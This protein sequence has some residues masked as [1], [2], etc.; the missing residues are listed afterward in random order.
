MAAPRV[1]LAF[2]PESG[3]PDRAAL[4]AAIKPLGFDFVVDPAWVPF[5]AP[6]YLPC[7]LEGEDAGV[8][9]RFERD[10]PLPPPAAALEA[11]RGARRALVQ[12]RWSGDPREQLAA[13]LLAAALTESFDAMVLEP[14]QGRLRSIVELLAQARALRESAF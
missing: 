10:A 9:V 8:Y 14:E 12:L 1:L 6:D 7:T 13:V 11:Q 2:L 5:A 3:V 4:Q